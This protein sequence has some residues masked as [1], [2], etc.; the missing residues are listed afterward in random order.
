M[1]IR[2]RLLLSF[3]II[4]LLFAANLVI[5][6]WSDRARAQSIEAVRR[7]IERQS[8]L[9][10]VNHSLLD[11]QKQ[12]TLLAHM[13]AEQ[14]SV[15]EIDRIRGRLELIRND[16][17]HALRLAEPE[18]RDK[19]QQ[20][21][22]RFSELAQSWRVFHE[23]LGVNPARAI[24]ELA[25][26]SEPLSDEVIHKLLPQLQEDEQRSVASATAQMYSIADL[27]GRVTFGIFS[28]SAA[29]AIGVAYLLSRYLTKRLDLL[30]LGADAIGSG[31]L[32]H[33]IRVDSSDELGELATA[34]NGM[35][36]SLRVAHEQLTGTNLELERR[37][38]ELD[39]E[40]QMSDS[41]LLN[42]LPPAVADELRTRGAVDPKVYQDVTILFTDFASFSVS[43]ENVES[44]RLIELLNE[45]FTAFDEIVTRYNLEKL[46]TIGDSYMCAGGIPPQ[47]GSHVVDA[48]LAAMEMLEYV[49][50]RNCRSSDEL[51]WDIRIGIH[52]G[53]VVAGVVGIRKFAFDVWGATV[54]Y[55]SRMES[56]GVIN[57]INISEQ[58]YQRIKEFFQCEYR[59][60]VPTKDHK[61]ADMYLV[62]AVHP[63]LSGCD[64]R[65]VPTAFA[66]KYR[67]AFGHELPSFPSVKSSVVAPSSRDAGAP[68]LPLELCTARIAASRER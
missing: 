10:S 55:S 7:T 42:I 60:K 38:A 13:P 18:H 33:E 35:S 53:P 50:D 62:S 58:T 51:C 47:S 45:Y 11:I 19:I 6:L 54:N 30:R 17:E 3:C 59:G 14:L 40:R 37:N 63:E 23:S 28:L 52:T 1:R 20:F 8:R 12:V 34:F 66:E 68:P 15:A 36:T 16:M 9:A 27:T 46:K 67:R 21:C 29:I 43:T 61:N 56:S 26:R 24:S 49:L 2:L 25:V 31:Q 5:H 39:T 65:T 22:T 4:L 57:R 48:V 41:L 64:S 32:H 44:R